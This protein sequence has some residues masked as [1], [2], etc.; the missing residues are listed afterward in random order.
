[1]HAHIYIHN[2][3]IRL[4]QGRRRATTAGPTIAETTEQLVKDLS[5]GV[6]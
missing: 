6:N 1:M 4:E 2:Y 3:T 5:L